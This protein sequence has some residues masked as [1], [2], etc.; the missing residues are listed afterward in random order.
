MAPEI[1]AGL[2]LRSFPSAPW[3]SRILSR[4]RR[5]PTPTE[6]VNRVTVTKEARDE[7]DAAI[8]RMVATIALLART[9]GWYLGA[10]LSTAMR[11][12]DDP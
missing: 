3:Y 10:H 11:A 2:F 5:S 4:L 9:P 12:I 8:R 7:I 6:N 1:S